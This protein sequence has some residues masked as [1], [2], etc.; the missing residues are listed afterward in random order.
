MV[1]RTAYVQLGR[2]PLM[3]ALCLLGMTLV[4]LVPPGAALLARGSARGLGALAWAAMA[5]SYLPTLRRFRLSP[6]WAPLLPLVAVFYMA[7]T[8]G[9]ALD[10][11]RG[12]GVVWKRRAYQDAGA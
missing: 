12:R 5:A 2:S 8:S 7:A 6:L 1:A 3:L 11:H 10:H 4:W 9:S